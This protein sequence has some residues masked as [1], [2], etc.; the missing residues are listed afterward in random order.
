MM[1][2]TVDMVFSTDNY[3]PNSVKTMDRLRRGTGS[4]LILKG[5]KTKKPVDWKSFL[6]N[7]ESKNQLIDLLVRLWAQDEYA[8]RL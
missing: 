5:E 4:K 7:D 8:S 6:C 1:L 2:K 3:V